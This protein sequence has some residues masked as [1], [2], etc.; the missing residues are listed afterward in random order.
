M[1]WMR[2]SGTEIETRDTE[3]IREYALSLGWEE[4]KRCRKPKP[5]PEAKPSVVT[6]VSGNGDS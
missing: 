4:V 1:K 5:K 6:K 3:E 2:P